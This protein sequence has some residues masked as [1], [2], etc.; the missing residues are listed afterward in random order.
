MEN[1][2][3][4]QTNRL[5]PEDKGNF[6]VLCFGNQSSNRFAWRSD[7]GSDIALARR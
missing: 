4:A 7:N 2:I 3:V 5:I 1:F 6:T